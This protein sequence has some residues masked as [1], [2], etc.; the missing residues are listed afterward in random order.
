MTEQLKGISKIYNN[1][2]YLD[3]NIPLW[4]QNAEIL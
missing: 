4:S 3:D 1:Y 2:R